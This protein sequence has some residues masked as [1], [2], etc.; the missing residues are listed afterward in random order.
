MNPHYDYETIF[1]GKLNYHNFSRTEKSQQALN[2]N[3]Y[4]RNP[5]IKAKGL[6]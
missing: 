4:T 2:K 3:S 6:N 1:R 5:E